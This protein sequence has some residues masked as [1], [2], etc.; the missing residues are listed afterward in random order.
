MSGTPPPIIPNIQA[1]FPAELDEQDLLDTIIY[2]GSNGHAR[3]FDPSSGPSMIL[4]LHL[5]P[6]RKLDLR[7]ETLSGVAGTQ[8]EG[9]IHPPIKQA[10]GHQG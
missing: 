1:D 5:N 10:H 7:Y 9:S 3:K 4:V 6:T 8:M 2:E